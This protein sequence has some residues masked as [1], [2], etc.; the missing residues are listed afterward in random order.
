MNINQAFSRLSRNIIVI[1]LAAGN[2]A[3]ALEALEKALKLNPKLK[4][5]ARSD[6]DLESLRQD[7]DFLKI[8]R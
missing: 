3:A 8:T 4:S 6:S 1:R 7:Q 5:Q 2:R